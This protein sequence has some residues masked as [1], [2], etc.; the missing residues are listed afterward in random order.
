MTIFNNTEGKHLRIFY[1]KMVSIRKPINLNFYILV[2]VL[3]SL[4]PSHLGSQH[5][6]RQRHLTFHL[7]P[8]HSCRQTSDQMI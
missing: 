3:R 1:L 2:V 6:A 5:A 8:S 7:H 4:R